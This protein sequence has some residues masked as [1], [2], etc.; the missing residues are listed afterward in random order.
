MRDRML[1]A[2]SGIII[3]HHNQD[4][5][6]GEL[7]ALEDEFNATIY[8]LDARDVRLATNEIIDLIADFFIKGS[9]LVA[10]TQGKMSDF[11]LQVKDLTV[12]D[13]IELNRLT[14]IEEDYLQKQGCEL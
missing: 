8:T 3:K 14:K 6:Y 2:I 4:Y 1:Q 11:E 5:D 7:M 12:G 10:E 9:Q 13:A